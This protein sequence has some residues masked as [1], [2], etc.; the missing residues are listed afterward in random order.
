MGKSSQ[1]TQNRDKGMSRIALK[2]LFR[3]KTRYLV[4]LG[5]FGFATLLMTQQ[6]G[7]FC[8]LMRWTTATVRQIDVP[9]WVMHPDVEQVNEAKPM[10]DTDADKV[11]SVQGVA[12]AVPITYDF[13]KAKLASGDYKQIVLLGLDTAT[14]VGR[15]SEMI[16]GN[17]NDIRLPDA[18]LIDDLAAQR[19]KLKVGDRMELNDKEARVVGIFRAE[20]NFTGLPYFMTTFDRAVQYIPPQRKVVS[21]VLAAPMPGQDPRAVARRIAEQTELRARASD[22]FGWDTIWWTFNNTGIPVAFGTTVLLGF[23]VGIA[24][25]GQTFYAFVMDN[26]KNLATFKAMGVENRLMGRMLLL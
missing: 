22:D 23:I 19:F 12:W 2:M 20:R 21:Y 9:I 10:E 11:R 8:G 17:I 6:A 7:I 24:V 18:V 3:D 5:A 4:L 25:A 13:L 16:S 1:S 26:L 14:L 15:P